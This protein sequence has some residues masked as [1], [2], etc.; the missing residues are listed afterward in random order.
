[1]G[2]DT[3]HA[4][5]PRA[6]KRQDTTAYTPRVRPTG[7]A[8]LAVSSTPKIP[9]CRKGFVDNITRYGA[10]VAAGIH[11]TMK[12]IV[13]LVQTTNKSDHMI[14]CM[15]DISTCVGCRITPTGSPN[16]DCIDNNQ[17]SRQTIHHLRVLL[18]CARAVPAVR[19]CTCPVHACAH[20]TP[21]AKPDIP[22]EG[23][24]KRTNNGHKACSEIFTS[25]H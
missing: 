22:M 14:V 1:M 8:Q 24:T 4:H 2:H 6:A 21:L 20:Y 25:I 9:C 15:D 7:T 5:A 19:V 13:R 11:R 18:L 16:L 10:Q 17:S 23:L 12:T 3:A